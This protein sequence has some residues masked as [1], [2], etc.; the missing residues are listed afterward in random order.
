MMSRNS[1]AKNIPAQ[2]SSGV[3]SNRPPQP[4]L[5]WSW[6]RLGRWFRL[7]L[8]LVL[9]TTPAAPQKRPVKP[10]PKRPAARP[11]AKSTDLASLVRDWREAP[12]PARRDLVE[13][14]ATTHSKD[15]A[16]PLARLALAVGDS[17]QKNYPAAIANLKAAHAI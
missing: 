6:S 3:F 5:P 16:G 14:Y 12:T 13:S 11:A 7:P 2:W 8:L 10:P 15:N 1:L 9:L 17:E 4:A